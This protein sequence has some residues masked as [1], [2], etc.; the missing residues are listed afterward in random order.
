MNAHHHFTF[1]LVASF[2]FQNCDSFGVHYAPRVQTKQ[3]SV[4]AD[5][6][7]EIEGPNPAD[8]NIEG[9]YFQLEE[10]EDAESRMTGILLHDNHT[11]SSWISDIPSCTN[12]D[13]TWEQRHDGRFAMNLIRT[14]SAGHK[15]NSFTD[16]GEFEFTMERLYLGD[17]SFVGAKIEVHGSVYISD[18][19]VG[20]EEV[21][22][23][24]MLDTEQNPLD[25][26]HDFV[27]NGMMMMK[28]TQR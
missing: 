8:V 25:A 23:F 6:S 17:M 2:F 16:M 7:L 20:D 27:P 21:G 3:M 13:G 19:V 24:S 26:E 14:Y 4:L 28:S 10:M 15:Q 9:R 12:V 1:A 18:E 5:P 22:Y 11:V